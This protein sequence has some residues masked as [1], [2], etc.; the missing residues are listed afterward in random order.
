MLLS[1]VGPTPQANQD[2]VALMEHTPAVVWTFILIGLTCSTGYYCVAWLSEKNASGVI[3]HPHKFPILLCARV[4]TGVLSTS[5]SKLLAV[6][7]GFLFCI[8]LGLFIGISF[9]ISSVAIL[10]ATEVDQASFVPAAACGIQIMN[11]LT[12][13]LIWQDYLVVQTWVGY[14]TVLTQIILGVY[15]ISS[16][17]AYSSSADSNFALAQSVKIQYASEFAQKKGKSLGMSL[18]G[19]SLDSMLSPIVED[20]EEIDNYFEERRRLYSNH[21]KYSEES[22]YSEEFMG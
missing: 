12:G 2:A 14:I 16:M 5:V 15:L 13:L 21:P 22:K 4:V 9:V 6:T 8:T 19:G 20:E 11:T 3:K 10:Q 17:D 18:V 1:Y 7:S